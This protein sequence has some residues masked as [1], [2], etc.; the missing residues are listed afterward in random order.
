MPQP[1][2]SIQRRIFF[3]VNPPDNYALWEEAAHF[4]CLH[5]PFNADCHR[6]GAVGNLVRFRAL[7]H[8]SE[9]MLQDPEKFV[10]HFGLAPHECLQSLHPLEI[11]N[12]YAA[13][14]T[15]NVWDDKNLFP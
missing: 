2:K 3:G 4:F 5:Y 10:G 1:W 13:G 12:D 7:N 6:G 9:G 11:G 14:V 8:L 15:Q